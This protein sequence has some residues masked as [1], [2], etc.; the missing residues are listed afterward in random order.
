MVGSPGGWIEVPHIPCPANPMALAAGARAIDGFGYGGAWILPGVAGQGVAGLHD[1]MRGEEVQFF[2][3]Q[4]LL[5]PK[6]GPCPSAGVSPA[7]TTSGSRP[8]QRSLI[9]LPAWWVNFSIW[10]RDTPCSPNR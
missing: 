2:G 3:A 1:V 7:P 5:Q 9:F 4:Q 10:L 6:A 8:D